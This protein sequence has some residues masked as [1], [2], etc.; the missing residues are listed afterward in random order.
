MS[1][2]RDG[3][4]VSAK[5]LVCESVVTPVLVGARRSALRI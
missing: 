2:I 5:L 1:S 3:F 4:I